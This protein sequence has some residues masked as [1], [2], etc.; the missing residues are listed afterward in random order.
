[1]ASGMIQVA[2]GHYGAYGQ[3][4]KIDRGRLVFSGPVDEVM[5]DVLAL[6]KV[7]EVQAGVIAAGNI[8]SPIIKLYS[9][10]PMPDTD[11]LSYIVLGSPLSKVRDQDESSLLMKAAGALVSAGESVV[12]RNQLSSQLGIDT[13]DIEA[14]SSDVSRSLV[15]IGKYLDPKLYVGLGGSLFTRTYQ[16]I[17]RYSLTKNLEV[18]TRAGTESSGNIYFKIEFE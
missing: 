8:R 4:L 13:L 14:G 11:I 1:M 18:E 7:G 6:Q 16:V 12:L 17:L 10:P 15:T 9:Q 3:R 5:L 2:E